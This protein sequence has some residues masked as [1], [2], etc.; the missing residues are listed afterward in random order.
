MCLKRNV[1]KTMEI[2]IP[3]KRTINRKWSMGYQMWW[4]AV[5]SAIRATAWLL[6]FIYF[7]VFDVSYAVNWCDK[8]RVCIYIC[9][10]IAG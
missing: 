1:S 10:L 3:F 7:A 2:E 4:N 5:R 9:C 6:V 8:L